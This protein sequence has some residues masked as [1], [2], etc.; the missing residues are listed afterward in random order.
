VASP[1][2]FQY[3]AAK[4]G[5][6]NSG[7]GSATFF[8]PFQVRIGGNDSAVIGGSGLAYN[9]TN[10]QT[11]INAI[12]GFAGTVTVTG[13][14]STGFSITYGGASA[15]LDV[16]SI[17]LINLGCDG[18]FASVEETNHGGAFD[19][20][21]LNYNGVDSALITNGVNYTSA[22]IQAALLPIL[23]A[24]ATVTINN[25]GGG[26]SPS[27]NGFQVTFGGTLAATNV[28]FMLSL[29]N[30]SA[31]ASSFVGETDKGGAVDNKGGTITPTGDAIPVVTAPAGYTIPLRTPFS[32]T[33]NATDA[34]GDTMTFSWEQNDR[35]GSAGTSLLN[36][37]KTNG[38][39]FAMF[40]KS[41]Q[42]SLSDS[43]Q[44]NS[45]GEN[46]LTTDPTRVFP[47]LQQIL[48]NNTNADTGA[49]PTGPIA[50]PVPQDVT[51]CFAEFL[52]TSDY[53]GFSGVNASPLSLHFRFTARDGK[54]GTNSTDTTLLL[55]TNAGPFLV[56]SPNTS[57][58]YQGGSTQTVTWN[59]ANTDVA[60][61]NT[62]NVKIS[63]SADGGYTYPYVLSASAPN[64]G[65]EP[66]TLPNI[67][68]TQAR[69]KI[70]AIDNIFFDLSNADFTIHAVPVVS[71]SLGEGGS[72]S[73]QY[74]DS[75]APDVTVTATDADSI[76][77]D[78][79]ATAVGLPDG[80][81]LSITS[82]TDNLPGSRTWKVA[83]ATT[84]APGSYPVTVTVT[85]ETGGSGTTSF[86][87][88]V[89]QEDAQATYTGDM[90]VFTAP[91]ASS[92]NVLLRA[93]VQDSSVI[94]SFN[95]TQPGDI[96]NASVTFKEGSTTLC[97]PLPVAL[98]DSDTT[99]GTASCTTSLG[100]GAH[101]V[102]VF[103]NNY[104]TGTTTGVVEVAQ[105]NGSFITGGGFLTI[106]RSGGVYQADPGSLMNFGFNVSYKNQKNLQGHVNV[107]FRQ[108]G[109]TYQIKSTALD[110]LGIAL[111]TANNKACSGPPS[112]DCFGVA[113][114]RSKANLT[115]VTDPNN[116]VS[117]GGNLTL[118]VT[119][120]DEGEPGSN[121]T[122]G[123]T[124]W[125]GNKLV[126]SS[127]WRG[128][129]TL[130]M[131]LGGGNLVVH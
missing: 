124:L 86:T 40:P 48:D 19:S 23:P 92:A 43:L 65:S 131:V 109:H 31:G 21:T 118:Q 121:D 59:P 105:P 27:S 71:S 46:H 1:R 62:A 39:L 75:L 3:T 129:K 5:L 29:T 120:T 6:A 49:C 87:I 96:R 76:G 66:V 18:C 57:V 72:Q 56:T 45:P 104:Y 102:D 2:T 112:P 119:M 130:E 100:L 9:A 20:F 103:V 107:I 51:E 25:F 30:M 11:A 122:I 88:L 41:G 126:F 12:A 4:S 22:G 82:T 52:P 63:L 16:P 26:G 8:S 117:L 93:T 38:P 28:P 111:K 58:N 73:V 81:S 108:A 98:I 94:P 60:P 85:D 101:Q 35:G 90:L 95:D 33:G 89:T 115:D 123:V 83:G 128:S 13:A 61:I 47:D 36:N 7:G 69:V 37:T 113:D 114:F 67:A 44:Y 106:D 116:P 79:S 17:E 78:L 53:V 80:L 127:E 34:D 15:G 68:T 125:D 50:Q 74:S 55:A 91:N 10:I 84:A 110:S 54:G 42:I 64:D 24:G 97:G 70:E 99:T 14:A 32:L 77:S